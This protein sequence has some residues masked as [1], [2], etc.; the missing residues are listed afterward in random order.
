MKII[1]PPI[2]IS[3]ESVEGEHI[4]VHVPDIKI[5]KKICEVDEDVVRSLLNAARE[6]AEHFY[7]VLDNRFHVGAAV[8]M[9]DDPQGRIWTGANSEM[10]VLNSGVCAERS[11]LNYLSGKGFRKI[12]YMAIS[13]PKNLDKELS[14]RSPCGLCR[15][16]IFEFSDSQTLVFIDKGTS[17]SECNVLDLDR[18]LP[19]GY[20]FEESK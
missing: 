7:S 6:A 8:I 20:R 12:K 11:I 16:T 18:L 2:N 15:Q 1:L 4:S 19:F 5:P 9:D 13:L 17:I 10:S 14:Y 3:G